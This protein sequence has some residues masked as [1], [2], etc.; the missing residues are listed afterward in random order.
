[1]R[2]HRSCDRFI[3][4]FKERL[5]HIT[6]YGTIVKSR[7]EETFIRIR[8]LMTP[9]M[10]PI[11]PVHLTLLMLFGKCPQCPLRNLAYN[12]NL[13]LIIFRTRKFL[14]VKCQFLRWPVL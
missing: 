3:L 8:F 14:C 7:F 1:M 2:R 5:Q 13:E 6:N 11:M 9:Y 12:Q 4:L 10:L